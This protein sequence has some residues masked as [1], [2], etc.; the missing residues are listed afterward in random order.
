V[1]LQRTLDKLDATL[2]GMMTTTSSSNNIRIQPPPTAARVQSSSS[3]STSPI[4]P[5]RQVS[6]IQTNNNNNNHSSAAKEGNGV[7]DHGVNNND[8]SLANALSQLVL[9]NP[10]VTKRQAAAQMLYLYVINL[11]SHPKVPRY[12]KIFSNNESYRTHVQHV[13]GADALLRAVGFVSR[14]PAW[15]WE[16]PPEEEQHGTNVDRLRQAAA[17][18]T[19]LKVVESSSSQSA[20]S[21][22]QL[23]QHVL[24]TVGLRPRQQEP[25]QQ[26]HPITADTTPPRS[27]SHSNYYLNNSNANM[28][29][30]TGATAGTPDASLFTTPVH[31]DIL[32]PPAT[33]KQL[34]PPR[35]AVD[36][37]V[38]IQPSL[39]AEDDDINVAAAESS[40]SRSSSS[41]SSTDY[42]PAAPPHIVSISSSASSH[43]RDGE[44][45]E[46]K[47]QEP[48][49]D[50]NHAALFPERRQPRPRSVDY[51]SEPET[52]TTTGEAAMWK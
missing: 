47:Q 20:L 13:A 36:F 3:A 35:L 14:G 32:S 28:M 5:V 11:S 15:E 44:D 17:A 6:H 1:R 38:L 46:G 21:P 34:T 30:D 4:P 27:N 48:A 40:S 39:L 7:N 33:K 9:D 52:S 10:D 29:N 22:E 12:R 49:M 31:A 25:P 26:Q 37:P 23:L 41:S 42:G 19:I 45:E 43:N 18:L 2:N 24:E 16:P 50:N 51:S 8:C